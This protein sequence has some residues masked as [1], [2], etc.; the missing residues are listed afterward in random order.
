MSFFCKGYFKQDQFLNTAIQ[1]FDL[2]PFAQRVI[3]STRSAPGGNRGPASQTTKV[4]GVRTPV[5]TDG[6]PPHGA[7]PVKTAGTPASKATFALFEALLPTISTGCAPCGGD[8]S[9]GE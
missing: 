2:A 7:P 5:A 8:H 9:L 3:S 4:R 1:R 6:P